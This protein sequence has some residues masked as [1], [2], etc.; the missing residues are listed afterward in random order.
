MGLLPDSLNL[1]P[2]VGA[3]AMSDGK[4]GKRYGLMRLPGI[5]YDVH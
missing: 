5:Y 1:N 2:Y 4:K 3:K